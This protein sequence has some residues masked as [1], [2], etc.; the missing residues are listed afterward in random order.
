MSEASTTPAQMMPLLQRVSPP[1]GVVAALAELRSQC[2]IWQPVEVKPG[3]RVS[4]SLQVGP[5]AAICGQL[6]GDRDPV[7]VAQ[8]FGVVEGVL[9]T[10]VAIAGYKMIDT[11]VRGASTMVSRRL[12]R[13][14]GG[15]GGALGNQDPV[16]TLADPV[17]AR[18]PSSFDQAPNR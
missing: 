4:A 12:R 16:E 5:E 7:A 6:V 2:T 8:F 1:E 17:G 18:R 11:I 3:D 14:C 9:I 13:S 10:L 15:V